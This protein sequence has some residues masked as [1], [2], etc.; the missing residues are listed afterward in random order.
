MGEKRSNNP[1]KR[2]ENQGWTD[3]QDT[4]ETCP[5]KTKGTQAIFDELLG[6]CNAASE[7]DQCMGCTLRTGLEL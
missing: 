5:S 7:D 2:T 1:V 3:V 4:T 6:D